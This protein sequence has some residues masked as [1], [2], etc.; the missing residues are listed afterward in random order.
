MSRLKL[1][2]YF[3][4]VTIV[5]LLFSCKIQEKDNVKLKIKPR[6]SKFLINKLKTNEFQ[7]E[8]IS[9]KASINLTDSL[10]KKTSFKTHLRIRKDSAIWISI[11]AIGLETARVII[12]QDSVK[13]INRIKKEYFLGDF[14]YINKV[15]ST[16]L[17]YQMLEALL[18]GNSLNFNENEKI[19][20]RV[21][22]KKELY[23][24]STEKK[25]KVKKG[26]QKVK[27]KIKKEAQVLWLDPISFK[28]KDLLLSS[29]ESNR[30]L[31]GFY[32]DY[33]EIK[34]QLVPYKIR[35]Q[36]KS[37]SSSTIEIDY[38][39]FSSGKSL[40]FPFKIS[41]KYAELQK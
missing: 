11:T 18:I 28:I 1:G 20:A 32:S 3:S 5:L 23:Y 39:K 41:A 10:N 30:S 36:L 9:A 33:K 26:L 12:T 25:R 6:S 35:F 4:I 38:S 24:L 15:F 37:K 8:T 17:D 34:E 16:E 7:F 22:R 14:N 31:A 27:E 29:P 40:S 21:D 2:Y 19:H 13:F